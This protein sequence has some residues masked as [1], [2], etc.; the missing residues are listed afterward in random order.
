[1]LDPESCCSGWLSLSADQT[2]LELDLD[3]AVLTPSVYEALV[4]LDDGEIQ[5]EYKISLNIL[6]MEA[7]VFVDWENH[8]EITM[9]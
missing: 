8:W 4:V 6:E 9:L 1:M 5:S 2:Y 3:S 7:P